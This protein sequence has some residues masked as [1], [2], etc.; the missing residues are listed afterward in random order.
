[1]LPLS[2]AVGAFGKYMAVS[3]VNDGP[4]TITIDSPNLTQKSAQKQDKKLGNEPE[5]AENE[6]TDES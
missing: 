5:L 2:P 6:K 1:M 3:I 4:V